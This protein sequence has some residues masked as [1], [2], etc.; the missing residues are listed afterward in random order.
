[1]YVQDTFL[2]EGV[3]YVEGSLNWKGE[4]VLIVEPN[5]GNRALRAQLFTEEQ[6]GSKTEAVHPGQ[7]ITFTYSAK[8]DP[9]A[10]ADSD[11][12][13]DSSSK[14]G[15]TFLLGWLFELIGIAK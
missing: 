1:M 2:N 6:G 10:T 8:V 4:G 7:S 15:D 5:F 9:S 13:P 12:A 14:C 3:A 11:A